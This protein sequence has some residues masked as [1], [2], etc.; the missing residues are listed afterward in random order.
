MSMNL[1]SI[2]R[3]YFSL[4]KRKEPVASKVFI[5][6]IFSAQRAT[7]NRIEGLFRHFMLFPSFCSK[8][9]KKLIQNCVEVN[10][11]LARPIYLTSIMIS[12]I[13]C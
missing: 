9:V 6:K 2:M 4:K 1:W 5:R 11:W 8:K 12:F 10:V 3:K 7:V 13:E